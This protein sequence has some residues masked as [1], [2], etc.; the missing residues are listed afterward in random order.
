MPGIRKARRRRRPRTRRGLQRL[1]LLSRPRKR[2]TNRIHRRPRRRRASNNSTRR[3]IRRR[4]PQPIR[5]HLRHNRV[6]HIARAH[7]VARA[8]ARARTQRAIRPRRATAMPRIRITR[9]RRRPRTR[10]DLQRLA[11]LSRPR[12]HRTNRVHRRPRRCSSH[13]PTQ[14]AIRRRAPETVRGH[15]RHDRVADIARAHQIA[16]AGART[17]TQRA[18]RARRITPVPRIRIA[19]RRRRPGASR[20]LQRLPLLRRPRKRRPH[21]IH[22]RPRRPARHDRGR[23]AARRGI[24]SSVRSD[25]RHQREP[26]IARGQ[27]IGRAR[28]RG[29]TQLTVRSCG[30]TT[31]PRIRIAR[32]RRRPGAGRDPQRLARLRRPRDCWQCGVTGTW[33]GG[34]CGRGQE[35]KAARSDREEKR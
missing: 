17:G 10:R 30:A 6:T 14:Q 13:N 23:S 7:Q 22:R 15:L 4:A 25:L 2:R 35:A 28:A 34:R 33:W 21:G 5:R 26:H 9:R 32:R 16:R 18:D 8:R 27:R 12:K 24:P 3:T 20:D 11:L 29:R 31:M 19:R 1:A